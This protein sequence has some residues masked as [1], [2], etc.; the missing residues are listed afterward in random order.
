[1]RYTAGKNFLRHHPS[2]ACQDYLPPSLQ[3]YPSSGD[4]QQSVVPCLQSTVEVVLVVDGVL[5]CHSPLVLAGHTGGVSGD[6][7]LI[8]RT[9]LRAA[10]CTGGE[11]EVP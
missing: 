4:N 7:Q 9:L 3:T 11:A 6:P 10:G 8:H 5:A 2:F 1:M